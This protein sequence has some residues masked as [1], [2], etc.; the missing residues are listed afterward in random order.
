[1]PG[2][3]ENWLGV[4][5]AKR[6]GECRIMRVDAYL[7]L[8]QSSEARWEFHAF[9][10]DPQTGKPTAAELERFG[11]TP[12]GPTILPGFAVEVSPGIFKDRQP[13]ETD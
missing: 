13:I 11:F 5:M 3:E 9:E 2:K 6:T 4:A 8:D 1:M 12:D 10:L 7:E